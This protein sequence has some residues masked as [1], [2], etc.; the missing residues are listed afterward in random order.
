MLVIQQKEV[1]S[2][3]SNSDFVKSIVEVIIELEATKA[4]LKI[5]IEEAN[6]ESRTL[7]NVKLGIV[8][9]VNAK[10]TTM[11]EK[12]SSEIFEL[13]NGVIRESSSLVSLFSEDTDTNIGG[14][15][16]VHIVGTISN[17]QRSALLK[18]VSDHCDD[19]SFLGG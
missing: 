10:L 18:L 19:F 17:T 3:N 7:M 15:D 11:P 2:N 6:G 16:H 12:E 4:I 9:K 8:D 1:D 13:G 5:V 14:L